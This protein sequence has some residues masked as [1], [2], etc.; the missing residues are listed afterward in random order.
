MTNHPSNPDDAAD[1]MTGSGQALRRQAEKKARA[2]AAQRP[3][4]LEALSP[5]DVRQALHELRVHQIELEMQNEQLRQT[6]TDM[7]AARVRYFDLYDLAPVGYCT[8]S[9][10]GLIL[11]ANLT[12]ATLLGA[13]RGAL[14]KQPF[15]RFILK[16]DQGL[17]YRHRKT[18]F[19]AGEPQVCELRMVKKD[20]TPF[21]AWLEATA[22][23]DADSKPVCRVVLSDITAR[24]E[25]ETAL[26]QA[27][28]ELEQRVAGRTEELRTLSSRQQAL[29]A[30]IPD[31]IV[32]V[33]K[34]KVF[35]WTNP[36][37][38]EFYGEGAL[39]KEAAFY[40]EGEQET[41]RVVTPLFGGSEDVIYVES[42]QRRKDGE[43]RLLAWWCRVLKDGGGNV[44]GALSA[45]RDITERTQAEAALLSRTRQL[46]AVREVT[47]EITQELDLDRLLALLAQRVTKLLGVPT[48]TVRLWDDASGLLMPWGWTAEVSSAIGRL[49][50]RLGE[51]V[52]GAAAERRTGLLVNDF[53]TSPYA[54]PALLAGP[55][56][57][58][59]AE[60]LLYHDRLVGVLSVDNG[61]TE[62][63]FTADD[64]TL[65]RLF[66]AHAAIAIENARL[67]EAGTR[68]AAQLASLTD[69]TQMVTAVLEP[70]ALAQQILQAAQALIPGAAGRLWEAEAGADAL[71]LVASVGLQDP[72]GG[73]RVPFW[74]GVAGQAVA[75][76]QPVIIADVTGDPGLVNKAWARAEGL[77][78]GIV[79]PLLHRDQA[80]G[81]FALFTR[82]P[83]GFPPDEVRL[84]S[85]FAAQAAIAMANARL[86]AAA[87]GQRRQ[88]E[89][90]QA[91]TAEIT[92]ELEV[93]RV[94]DLILDRAMGLLDTRS[95]AIFLWDEAAQVLVPQA[96]VGLGDWYGDVRRHQ[97]EGVVGAVAQ[98]RAGLIVN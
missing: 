47:A 30:A 72:A 37:G 33:D 76:R 41:Y 45:G 25:A 80:L 48:G 70:A 44:I 95:G 96:H 42:W 52:A 64:Q 83:H 3:E 50:L 77:V 39:G 88:L 55:H 89:A 5:E 86:Y 54:T 74:Q 68:R 1:P 14:S 62:R 56:T 49:P 28:D 19:G 6:Q 81:V 61:T 53:R 2:Q 66:A 40:F 10:Q 12:A 78:S 24:K 43:R 82:V 46:E 59:L 35:T 22:A 73:D 15:S 75:T 98:R 31:I 8:I 92:R 17:Y 7:D 79:L 21:W 38:L 91:V 60:P 97:G 94:L 16:E 90:V 9:K 20:G 13:A 32:E 69:L 57:A 87:D 63:P 27:H 58:V 65:L 84:L 23:Q 85:A 4:P 26:R 51:G 67:H 11:E 34:N 93:T 29:L 36:A 18:L 71:R